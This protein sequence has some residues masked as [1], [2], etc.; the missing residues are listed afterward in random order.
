MFRR[1]RTRRPCRSF[2]PCQK[3]SGSWSR[4]RWPRS[5]NGRPPALQR[6]RFILDFADMT[7]MRL[8]VLS[9]ARLGRLRH[10]QLDDGEWAWS[11]MVL[12]ERSKWREVPLPD[13]PGVR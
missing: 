4:H 13:Q 7:G 10:E 3:S 11:I 6:L 5:W 8:S 2:G 1:S 9:A 12:G